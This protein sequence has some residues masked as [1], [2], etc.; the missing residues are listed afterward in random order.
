MAAY[1]GK[2]HVVGGIK[3]ADAHYT[4]SGSAWTKQSNF[5]VDMKSCGCFVLNGQL[6]AMS[7]SYIDMVYRYTGSTW[8]EVPL[9]G[10]YASNYWDEESYPTFCDG[11]NVY[12]FVKG[13]VYEWDGQTDAWTVDAVHSLTTNN[14][15]VIC[16]NGGYF[17][18]V[19]GK[20]IMELTRG[21]LTGYMPAGTKIYSQDIAA[22]RK[23]VTV[24]TVWENGKKNWVIVATVKVTGM[25]MVE[26]H[27]ED[28]DF[29]IV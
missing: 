21:L 3:D 23:N 26:F 20:T 12:K 16:Y 7:S 24:E 9:G 5:P 29:A 11:Y 10:A 22:G 19:T 17:L 25:V 13:Y 14:S 8:V 1:N 2:L 27:N 18:F 15:A 6:Y 4:F 28:P